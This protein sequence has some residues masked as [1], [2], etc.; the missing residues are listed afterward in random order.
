MWKT[1][2][3]AWIG[4]AATT[5]VDPNYCCGDDLV[6]LNN[7]ICPGTQES[8]SQRLCSGAGAFML[9]LIAKSYEIDSSTGDLS[10]NLMGDYV[11][12]EKYC[13]AKTNYRNKEQQMAL[14]CLDAEGVQATKNTG[15]GVL[16]TVICCFI[17]IFFLGVTLGVYGLLPE[18]RDL[19]GKCLMSSVSSL[20]LAFLLLAIVQ[21]STQVTYAACVALAMLLYFFFLSVFFWLNVVSF[22]VWRSSQAAIP[23]WLS[24]ADERRL[25]IFY[26][27][28]GW[29]APLI[30]LLI[31]VACHFAPGN[32]LRPHFG[33]GICWFGGKAQIW[34]YFY[35]PISVLLVANII[36]F[37][38]TAWSLWRRHRNCPE[39]HLKSHKFK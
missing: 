15:I 25:F 29:G 6:L 4:L 5:A 13:L 39:R 18:L 9:P 36:M 32:H 2:V 33:L 1:F 22:N 3:V 19:Q 34:A 38:A 30:M 10:V 26:N 16:E 11:S 37:V 7:D 12:K 21:L 8:V 35:G 20:L 27:A 24:S 28:Y 17:S 31:S 23:T 14:I